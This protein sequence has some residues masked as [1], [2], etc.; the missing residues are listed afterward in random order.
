M[1]VTLADVMGVM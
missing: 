1:C